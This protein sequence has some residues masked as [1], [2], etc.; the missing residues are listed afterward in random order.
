MEQCRKFL[1]DARDGAVSMAASADK[2]LFKREK[3]K[4]GTGIA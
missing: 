2:Y 1:Q 3:T 4:F